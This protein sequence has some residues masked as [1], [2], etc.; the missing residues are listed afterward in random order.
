MRRDLLERI[1]EAILDARRLAEAERDELAE[2]LPNRRERAPA[3]SSI[4]SPCAGSR[5]SGSRAASVA[6]ETIV[7]SCPSTPLYDHCVA[8]SD[9][10]IPSP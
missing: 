8:A 10:T 2:A 1:G 7:D 5:T 4:G 9:Q 6:H 3:G